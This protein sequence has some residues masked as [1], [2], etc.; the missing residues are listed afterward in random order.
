VS[1]LKVETR[2]SF[3]LPDPAKEA[4]ERRAEDDEIRVVAGEDQHHRDRFLRMVEILITA[5]LVKTRLGVIEAGLIVARSHE[6]VSKVPTRE[7]EAAAVDFFVW[8]FDVHSGRVLPSDAS[9]DYR[10][11]AWLFEGKSDGNPPR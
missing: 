10:K 2:E 6:V 8:Q 5:E 11:P 4:A 3:K 9:V 1:R 7:P